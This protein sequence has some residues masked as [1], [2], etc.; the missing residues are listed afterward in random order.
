MTEQMNTQYEKMG[1]TIQSDELL[2]DPVSKAIAASDE[3]ET[4]GLA[5]DVLTVATVA[6]IIWF[7]VTQIGFPWL[8]EA[9]KYSDLWRMRVD[10][11]IDSEYSKQGFDEEAIKEFTT[12]FKTELE[13]IEDANS[14]TRW[15]SLR[16]LF[17]SDFD[18]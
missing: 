11:W 9:K 8:H 13:K 10:K 5:G 15:M 6:P 4:L 7:V 2:L 12:R 18:D 17:L 14:R 1:N 3:S 16:N